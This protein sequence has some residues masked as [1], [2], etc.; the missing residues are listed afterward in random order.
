MKIGFIGLGNMGLPMALNLAKGPNN[1]I[2]F[3]TVA[4][5]SGP[6]TAADTAQAAVKNADVVITMLPNG[7]ILNQV[8]DDILPNVPAGA[9]MID[10]ST[11]DVTEARQAA[12]KADERGLKAV[13]APVSGGVQGAKDATLTFMVGAHIADF[14][15]AEAVL[16]QMGGKIVDCGDQGA[17]QAAKLCNN[18]LLGISM[19]GVCEA[20]ALADRL[21]LSRQKF[22][23]VAASA[24]GS[25]WSLN[26]YCP[27]PGIG[28]QSPS[29][30][31]YQPG[32]AVELMLKDLNLSQQSANNTGTPTRMGALAAEIY[33]QFAGSTGAGRDFSAYLDEIGKPNP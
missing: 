18:M 24:S 25:C 8:Y 28:P 19:L 26:T 13:D 3:D 27:A 29:D 10:C 20:F 17:G 31:G 14:P 7:R 5:V 23:D 1:V 32:F 4:S 33:K 15:A 21:G 16:S 6:I 30:N 12:A 2:G 22:F 11:V 9:L